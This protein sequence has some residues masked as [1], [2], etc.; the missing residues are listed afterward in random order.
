MMLQF[1]ANGSM[2]EQNDTIHTTTHHEEITDKKIEEISN[3]TRLVG[4]WVQMLN[5]FEWGTKLS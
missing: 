4:K 1:A 5:Y 2:K 3:F